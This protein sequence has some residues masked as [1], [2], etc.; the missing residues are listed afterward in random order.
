MCDGV[1]RTAQLVD[2]DGGGAGFALVGGGNGGD[3]DGGA[4]DGG[5]QRCGVEPGGAHG[6]VGRAAAG[7]SVDLPDEPRVQIADGKG[8]ELLRGAVRDRN[9]RGRDAGNNRP[10]DG[11]GR[12]GDS[13]GGQVV[14]VDG[15]EVDLAVLSATGQVGGRVGGDD[16]G[17][18]I[19]VNAVDQR[20][21]SRAG[22]GIRAKSGNG[23]VDVGGV[24]VD[25]GGG[26]SLR[27]ANIGGGLHAEADRGGAAAAEAAG[28]QDTN[29]YGN[30]GECD[31]FRESGTNRSHGHP[32]V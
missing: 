6:T 7:D 31:G 17:C 13:G 23:K 29:Q 18:G 15:G 27:G 22:D 19:G 20:D 11:G 21:G 24:A 26:Q 2:G 4:G 32:R 5:S 16:G 9:R 3:R 28:G 25:Y 10:Q 1:Q 12:R 14:S 8:G 30:R